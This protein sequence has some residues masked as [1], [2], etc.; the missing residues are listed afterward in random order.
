V[1]SYKSLTEIAKSEMV[2]SHPLTVF[3]L[4]VMQDL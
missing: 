1:K 4:N 3:V 2:M